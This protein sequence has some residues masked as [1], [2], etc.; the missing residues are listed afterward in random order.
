MK[1][2]KS[3]NKKQIAVISGTNETGKE[4]A[5]YGYNDALVITEVCSLHYGKVSTAILTTS[6]MKES[7]ATKLLEEWWKNTAG[8]K[9]A[10]WQPVNQYEE[11]IISNNFGLR[12][13]E[14]S[15]YLFNLLN[16]TGLTDLTKQAFKN[17]SKREV[18]GN[19]TAKILNGILAKM[20]LDAETLA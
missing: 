2:T 18:T 10:H 20:G 19:E 4:L 8:K 5:I 17:L 3:S 12:G 13:S 7:E 9:F 16:A 6:N 14:E 15:D 1:Q 11:A